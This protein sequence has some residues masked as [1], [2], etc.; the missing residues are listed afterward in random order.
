MS[1]L[2]ANGNVDYS[3]IPAFTVR[4]KQT[5][6]TD[7]R[8]SIG[9]FPSVHKIS[10]L[11]QANTAD[12]FQ[13]IKELTGVSAAVEGI[14]ITVHGMTQ[15]LALQKY[16][17][18]NTLIKF[19]GITG[20]VANPPTAD[21]FKDKF[22]IER[23]HLPGVGTLSFTTDINAEASEGIF[24][25]IEDLSQISIAGITNVNSVILAPD[26]IYEALLEIKIK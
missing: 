16:R 7:I 24:I 17:S 1:D 5:N 4:G 26:T 19:G 8:R 6:A 2:D 3:N 12:T 22:M 11:R 13:T 23:T 25:P 21:F 14:E 20:S 15:G 18:H 10:N 9:T